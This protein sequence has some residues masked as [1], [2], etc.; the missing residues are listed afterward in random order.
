VRVNDLSPQFHKSVKINQYP[1]VRLSASFKENQRADHVVVYMDD[2]AIEGFNPGL[3][4]LKLMNTDP[5]VPSIY[6]RTNDATNLSIH[7]IPYPVDSNT[8]I[9]LG[10]TSAKT[11]WIKISVSLMENL[12]PGIYVYLVDSLTRVN[13]KLENKINHDVFIQE[14]DN[15]NRF[16]LVFS[17]SDL[18]HSPPGED[19]FDA[20]R[21]GNQ[22]HVYIDHSLGVKAKLFI[23][24][25]LGQTL[26]HEELNGGGN[27]V[28]QHRFPPGVYILN[29]HTSSGILSKKL[30]I[31]NP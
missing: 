12:P 20:Y 24:N 15:L 21:S 2:N 4:A 27:H 25:M 13:R 19:G 6:C 16:T 10:I 31:S 23:N 26:M 14:G 17:H 22:I 18:E 28:I 9:P 30:Y 1:L 5:A 3:D 11:G 29:L 8:I 7:A